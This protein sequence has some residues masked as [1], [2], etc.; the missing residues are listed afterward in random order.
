MAKS[1]KKWRRKIS[2]KDPTRNLPKTPK[3]SLP[4]K[5]NRIGNCPPGLLPELRVRVRL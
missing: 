5:V 4:L 3:L 2:P 1:R